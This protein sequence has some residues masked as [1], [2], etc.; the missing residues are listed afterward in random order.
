MIK[1]IVFWRLKDRVNGQGKA[2]IALELK[3]RLEAL[4]GVVPGL[5]HLEV[6][7]DFLKSESSSDLALYT[8]FSSREALDAYQKHPAHKEFVDFSHDLR[9]ERRVVDYEV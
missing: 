5:L 6:G 1:H 3:K 4:R 9:T 7:L 8:E 2:E